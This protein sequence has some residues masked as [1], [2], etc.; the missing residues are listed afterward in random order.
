[1]KYKLLVLTDHSSQTQENSIFA[2]LQAMRQDPFCEQIDIAT[3]GWEQNRDFF[4][5][6]DATRLYANPVTDEFAYHPDGIHFKTGLRAVELE[7]YDVLFLRLP[8]PIN[9]D[10]LKFLTAHFPDRKI[11][12]RPSGLMNTASKAYLLRFP[13]LC[14]EMKL[15]ESAADIRAFSEKFPIVLKPLRNYGGKGIVK[16]QRGQV[17]LDGRSTTLDAFL[18]AYGQDPTPYLGMRFLKN[19]QRGDKRIV[20]V[21]GEV[22]GGVLRLPPPGAWLCNAAQGG[23]ATRTVI[24]PEEQHI[25]E[26]IGPELQKEGIAMYGFDTLEDDNGKRVL[27][28]IN[29]LSIGGL[30][31][32]GKLNDQPVV[33]RAAKLLWTHINQELYGDPN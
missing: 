11:I 1:M 30:P 33:S 8:P 15:C 13:Q 12:N 17:D 28:E 31:Q 19:V 29:T 22:L 32:M 23:R 4:T 7:D 20:V 21:N 27:S 25:A 10:F 18:E 5:G 14:P 24:T 3:R 16:I 26:V 9:N 6:E 2:L